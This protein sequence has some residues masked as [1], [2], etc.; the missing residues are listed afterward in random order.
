[1]ASRER[2]SGALKQTHRAL[3]V[4]HVGEKDV[5]DK[6][7]QITDEQSTTGGIGIQGRAFVGCERERVVGD[8]LL[9]EDAGTPQLIGADSDLLGR[10]G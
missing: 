7:V 9:N 1:M 5:L 6:L 3:P 4:I 2:S 10:I 8:P